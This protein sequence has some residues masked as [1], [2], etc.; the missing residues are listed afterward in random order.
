MV[1]PETGKTTH[2]MQTHNQLSHSSLV[3]EPGCMNNRS[4]VMLSGEGEP[5]GRRIKFRGDVVER[6]QW[7]E[8][9]EISLGFKKHEIF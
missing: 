3:A 5:S 7:K 6:A 9:P 4:W 1:A 8:D 2:G